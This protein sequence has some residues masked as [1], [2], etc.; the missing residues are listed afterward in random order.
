MPR[1]EFLD[2][3]E[4]RDAFRERFASLARHHN[5]CRLEA[6]ALD[7]DVLLETI[8]SLK[9]RLA[10]ARNALK[11]VK[12]HH[13]FSFSGTTMDEVNK[14]L[15]EPDLVQKSNCCNAPMRVAGSKEGTHWH[16]CE[17]CGQPC[18]AALTTHQLSSQ[19]EK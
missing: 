13:G 4:E 1:S 6:G 18:D 2:L 8:K 16:E 15:A 19:T 5:L 14:A 9:E 12:L 17:A 10:L 3:L 7:D 11:E